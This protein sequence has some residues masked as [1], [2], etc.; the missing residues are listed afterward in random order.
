[1]TSVSSAAKLVAVE[2]L[3]VAAVQ[4]A[5]LWKGVAMPAGDSRCSKIGLPVGESQSGVETSLLQRARKRNRLGVN[6]VYMR[7]SHADL[8]AD[9]LQRARAPR[10]VR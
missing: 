7:E 9:G 2:H 3:R 5:A 4:D 10:C 8:D 1:M 6:P